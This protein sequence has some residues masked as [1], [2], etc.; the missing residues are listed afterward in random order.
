MFES[1]FKQ[2]R[3]VLRYIE[4]CCFCTDGERCNPINVKPK[5]GHD[6]IKRETVPFSF[7]LIIYSPQILWMCAAHGPYTHLRWFACIV[8]GW[9]STLFHLSNTHALCL[10]FRAENSMW[11][12][13][14]VWC[15]PLYSLSATYRTISTIVIHEHTAHADKI[16]LWLTSCIYNTQCTSGR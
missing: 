1:E 8:E 6:I 5:T 13:V 9:I 11:R 14:A 3:G 10:S 2:I 7:L 15:F 4:L 16:C 12:C